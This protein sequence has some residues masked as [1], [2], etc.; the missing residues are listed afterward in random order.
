MYG[1]VGADSVDVWRRERESSP[2]KTSP[3]IQE[4]C[5]RFASERKVNA[6]LG[7]MSYLALGEPR[8]EG[9]EV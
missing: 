6:S 3:V 2:R 7:C 5:R 9:E 1:T 4:G 8:S